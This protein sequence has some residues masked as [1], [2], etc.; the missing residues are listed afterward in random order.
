MLAFSTILVLTTLLRYLS[1]KDKLDF[2]T[3]A[4]GNGVSPVYTV[5][6]GLPVSVN[7]MG[8]VVV[9]R[10]PADHFVPDLIHQYDRNGKL[11]SALRTAYSCSEPMQIT[12]I[13][14]DTVR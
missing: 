12:T 14:S 2:N 6:Y 3:V 1:R 5:G 7:A 10:G 11:A 8:Q 13:D 4:V 9:S